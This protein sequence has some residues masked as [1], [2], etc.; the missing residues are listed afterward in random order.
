LMSADA[1]PVAE[2]AP[3]IARMAKIGIV[4]GVARRGKVTP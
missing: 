1:P 4:P 3:M 2:D